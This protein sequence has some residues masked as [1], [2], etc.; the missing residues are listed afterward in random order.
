[1]TNVTKANLIFDFDGTLVDSGPGILHTLSL[2]LSAR[3]LQ[4]Q[5]PLTRD[6]IGPP[7]PVTLR[8]LAG[9]VEP[10]LLDALVT[11]FKA[12]Y[13]TQGVKVT[14]PYAGIVDTITALATAGRR[15]HLATNKREVPTLILLQQLG[16]MPYFTSV[17][18]LDSR[19]PGFAN[20]GAML[21]SQLVEQGLLASESLYIGDTNHDEQAAAAANLP[22]VAVGWGYGVGVQQVSADARLITSPVDL[23]QL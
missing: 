8:K 14:Q 4:P 10:V 17:Y 9:D 23:L 16:L 19:S 3:G 13:D 1:M 18:C 7:L 12:L 21:Q 6:L 2:V 15:L 5:L 22:F 11:E 20:K